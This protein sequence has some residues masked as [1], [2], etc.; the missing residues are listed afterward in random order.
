MDMPIVNSETGEVL[1]EDLAQ[2]YEDRAKT[3]ETLARPFE[4]AAL[5]SRTGSGNKEFTYVSTDTVI[6][7]LNEATNNNWSFEIVH[8][9]FLESIPR[10]RDGNRIEQKV[11]KVHGRLTIPEFG[12]RDGFGVQVVDWPIGV[13]MD[14][15]KA[16][17]GDALKR[18][19]VSFG[20]AIDL[21]GK[22]L[23]H[24]AEGEVA[25]YQQPQARPASANAPQRQ[26]APPAGMKPGAVESEGM[27]YPYPQTAFESAKTTN[28]DI[29]EYL[30]EQRIKIVARK[31]GQPDM[32]DLINA[33]NTYGQ[34]THK[35]QKIVVG[36]GPWNAQ[37]N[38]HGVSPR[39]IGNSAAFWIAVENK[40]EAG[41]AAKTEPQPEP[42]KAEEVDEWADIPF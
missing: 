34:E 30:T 23:E 22:D 26:P 29:I 12:A 41:G 15:L 17:P 16:A 36:T 13:S 32:R 8:E 14:L 1:A 38:E 37:Y 18:A 10:F 21:Y 31:G 24:L 11:H 4:G 42:E 35:R 28:K 39:D 3:V 9:A 33:V 27:D 40:R 19:A 6:R 2:L 7:R 20:V 25:A 5:K